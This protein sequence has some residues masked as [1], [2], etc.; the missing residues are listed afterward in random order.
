MKANEDG[1][2]TL[3]N[4]TYTYHVS[5]SGYLTKTD[6]FEVTDEEPNQVIRVMDLEKF[7]NRVERYRY[8]LQVR[9]PYSARPGMLRSSRR[10][11]IWRQTVMYS[12]TTAVIP[13]CMHFWMQ[14]KQAERNLSVT[15]A[16]SFLW[17]IPLPKTMERK[18]DGYARSTVS[19][20]ATRRTH[21][22]VIRIRLNCSITPMERYAAC[23]AVTGKRGSDTG[24]EYGTASEWS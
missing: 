24:R 4:G 5:K 14:R 12:T 22:L 7:R 11:R 13:S 23:M 16:N 20:A 17:T 10:Q 2:Y 8:S 15:V 19:S 6:N 18:Q 3:E 1:T 21:W 9:V